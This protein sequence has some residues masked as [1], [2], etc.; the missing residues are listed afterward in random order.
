MVRLLGDQETHDFV[1]LGWRSLPGA[2]AAWEGSI[3]TNPNWHRDTDVLA[4]GT[5]QHDTT[6]RK[7]GEPKIGSW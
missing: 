5:R 6:D 2:T 7:L 3:Q 1:G 4:C